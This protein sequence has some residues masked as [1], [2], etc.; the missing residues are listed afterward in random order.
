M[1]FK[2]QQ[3]HSMFDFWFIYFQKTY[4]PNRVHILWIVCED[5]KISLL[6]L[7]WYDKIIISTIK[8]NVPIVLKL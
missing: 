6:L 7:Y 1:Y 2:Y 3:V 8:N 4:N 5:A